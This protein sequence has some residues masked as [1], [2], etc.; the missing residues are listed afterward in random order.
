M[1]CFKDSVYFHVLYVRLR[2]I[3]VRK[4]TNNIIYNQQY[5]I[6]NQTI[7]NMAYYLKYLILN[8]HMKQNNEENLF[9]NYIAYFNNQ[10]AMCTR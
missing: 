1:I 6:N 9:N 3:F 7:I 8:L 4:R 5:T 10:C 2:T